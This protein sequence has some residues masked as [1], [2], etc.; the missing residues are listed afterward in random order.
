MA[1][2]Y[3]EP[4]G[5]R[6]LCIGLTAS[7]LPFILKDPELS[8]A[9]ERRIAGTLALLSHNSVSTRLAFPEGPDTS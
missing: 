5:V 9:L 7:G 8:T 1:K 3:M 4:Y 2:N 6:F